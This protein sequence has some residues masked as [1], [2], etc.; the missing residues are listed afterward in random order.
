MP[1]LV[2][3]SLE[4]PPETSGAALLRRS[5]AAAEEELYGDLLTEPI[6]IKKVRD[7]EKLEAKCQELLQEAKHIADASYNI[8]QEREK[9]H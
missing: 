6:T 1:P 3:R 5:E 8:L 7:A 2:A 4:F 9:A